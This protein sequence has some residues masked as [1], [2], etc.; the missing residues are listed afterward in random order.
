MQHSA[1][2]EAQ[3]AITT[4]GLADHTPGISA[5]KPFLPIAELIRA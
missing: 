4:F 5:T 1:E 2:A 3:I